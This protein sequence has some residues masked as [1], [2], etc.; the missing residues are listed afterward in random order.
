MEA[1]AGISFTFYFQV[2]I[3]KPFNGTKEENKVATN[4]R[5]PNETHNLDNNEL[6]DLHRTLHSLATS[7]INSSDGLQSSRPTIFHP[8]GTNNITQLLSSLAHGKYL[9]RPRNDKHKQ[10]NSTQNK[11]RVFK[12]NKPFYIKDKLKTQVQRVINHINNHRLNYTPEP[13]LKQN[14]LSKSRSMKKQTLI[15]TKNNTIAKFFNKDNTYRNTSFL[16]HTKNNSDQN[17][18]LTSKPV[19]VHD[20]S[21]LP[22]YLSK[23]INNRTRVNNTLL[24]KKTSD[25]KLVSYSPITYN[26]NALQ[27]SIQKK[28]NSENDV[29]SK[30]HMNTTNST[31]SDRAFDDS[32]RADNKHD[33]HTVSIYD[34]AVS[35]KHK[36]ND[37]EQYLRNI[38]N[39]AGPSLVSNKENNSKISNTNLSNNPNRIIQHFNA[40]D[41]LKLSKV[42]TSKPQM[43]I[44]SK[45]NESNVTDKSEEGNYNKGWFNDESVETTSLEHDK[46]TRN[47]TEKHPIEDLIDSL[48][49]ITSSKNS[50]KMRKKKKLGKVSISEQFDTNVQ[51][52]VTAVASNKNEMNNTPL[53]NQNI[54]NKTGMFPDQSTRTDLKIVTMPEYLSS[55]DSKT[56]LPKR[57]ANL[58]SSE[59]SNAFNLVKV[60]KPQVI[61]QLPVKNSESANKGSYVELPNSEVFSSKVASEGKVDKYQPLF[62]KYENM[63][64]ELMNKMNR[65][66]KSVVTNM[67]YDTNNSPYNTQRVT[68][69]SPPSTK[70]VISKTGQE[71][72]QENETQIFNTTKVNNG[73]Y[74]Y[75]TVT[76]P[77]FSYTV[78]NEKEQTTD[79]LSETWRDKKIQINDD[80]TIKKNKSDAMASWPNKTTST[81][82]IQSTMNEHG[83]NITT[84]NDSI[85]ISSAVDN[86]IDI[87]KEDTFIT[88]DTNKTDSPETGKEGFLPPTTNITNNIENI[89]TFLNPNAKQ[90]VHQNPTPA[91]VEKRTTIVP[92]KSKTLHS[93]AKN[94]TFKV[95]TKGNLQNFPSNNTNFENTVQ[96][97]VQDANNNGL[98]SLQNDIHGIIESYLG[99]ANETKDLRGYTTRPQGSNSDAA[100]EKVEQEG[101]AEANNL[102]IRSLPQ[103]EINLKKPILNNTDHQMTGGNVTKQV[104]IKSVQTKEENKMTDL[105][106]RPHKHSYFISNGEN[107]KNIVNS[108]SITTDYKNANKTDIRQSDYVY[109]IDKLK[110]ILNQIGLSETNK[111]TTNRLNEIKGKTANT[112]AASADV[113]VSP[114]FYIS[115]KNVSKNKEFTAANNNSTT[116]AYGNPDMNKEGQQVIKLKNGLEVEEEEFKQ[117]ITNLNDILLGSEHVLSNTRGEEVSN[118]QFDNH[119]TPTKIS[120]NEPFDVTPRQEENIKQNSQLNKTSG[121]SSIVTPR[122]LATMQQMLLNSNNSDRDSSGSNNSFNL[123]GGST[124]GNSNNTDQVYEVKLEDIS[125]KRTYGEKNRT[126]VQQSHKDKHYPNTSAHTKQMNNT[127]QETFSDRNV[128]LEFQKVN[129]STPSVS[130]STTEPLNGTDNESNYKLTNVLNKNNI[131]SA[132]TQKLINAP[133]RLDVEQTANSLKPLMSIKN[134]K[135]AEIQTSVQEK[136]KNYTS[137]MNTN[138]QKLDQNTRLHIIISPLVSDHNVSVKINVEHNNSSTTAK[139]L[140]LQTKTSVNSKNPVLIAEN[141]NSSIK[142][143]PL[144]LQTEF[145]NNSESLVL[146]GENKNRFSKTNQSQLQTEGTNN[147]GSPV[148]IGESKN[149]SSKT[150]QSQL[151]SKESSNS[152]SPVSLGESKNLTSESNSLRLNTKESNNSGGPVSIGENK[153]KS[154]ITTE[155]QLQ[156]NETNNLGSPVFTDESKNLSSQSINLSNLQT[157]DSNSL[158]S[159]VLFVENLNRSST[160]NQSQILTKETNSSG[161]PVSIAE[162]KNMSSETNSLQLRTNETMNSGSPVFVDKNQTKLKNSKDAANMMGSHKN[163]SLRSAT[164]QLNSKRK[165]D[166]I[167]HN[168]SLY[169]LTIPEQGVSKNLPHEDV[170]NSITTE[171]L[172][173]SVDNTLNLKSNGDKHISKDFSLD[174]ERGNLVTNRKRITKKEEVVEVNEKIKEN[175][176]LG[177]SKT[178][179][180]I[181]T[182]VNSVD[183]L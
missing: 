59:G 85:K 81:K 144:Q 37:I 168:N 159:Q 45:K 36:P 75:T 30:G 150:N 130:K 114:N 166:K 174:V 15:T 39:E 97:N 134:K 16:N 79:S 65:R 80:A 110:T 133:V 32:K 40:S 105:G 19:I 44:T 47:E 8:Y 126:V 142:I 61:T 131:T 156:T 143:N 18:T 137:K 147:L 78:S 103:N 64:K 169:L 132:H 31:I 95:R 102:E 173:K 151:K 135:D 121:K 99:N 74:S 178:V 1:Q 146:I 42:H 41:D 181:N 49:K 51:P 83:T 141:E 109:L 171:R 12:N 54:K 86:L 92:E 5:Y 20:R 100:V 53:N 68:L 24:E 60:K 94:N 101:P 148:S 154:S 25:D 88:S 10:M 76:K 123:K 124:E 29:M 172:L 66:N 155:S 69:Y 98:E 115:S 152:V 52:T 177:K 48:I 111:S 89:N 162:N 145:T 125:E 71:R 160:K 70:R 182:E 167:S 106:T 33:F 46:I 176:I 63:L 17:K 112:E 90:L 140:Q 4:K 57:Y 122:E 38:S 7:F 164:E 149:R 72:N 77:H 56:Y 11:Q 96:E 165:V 3:S 55:N 113:D 108:V 104:S 34:T 128:N 129:S 179:Q 116:H 43:N 21:Y 50:L 22:T 28:M 157:K 170:K 120:K 67:N 175:K 163:L 138:T 107:P 14:N 58:A 180:T 82:K 87:E 119:S 2:N 117:L 127:R 26:S 139:E 6:L 183:Y 27:S 9:S 93:N 136:T 153:N 118:G 84:P 35:R 91:F 161:S 62:L 23:I 158:G 73:T 13:K